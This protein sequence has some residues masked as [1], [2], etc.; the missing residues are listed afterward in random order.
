M[1]NDLSQSDANANDMRYSGGPSV[2]IFGDSDAAVSDIRDSVEANGARVSFQGQ[3]GE[4]L[5]AI[6]QQVSYDALL[7]DVRHSDQRTMAPVLGELRRIATHDRVPMLIS[8]SMDLLD[9]VVGIADA[10]RITLL[11]QPNVFE[12]TA[13]LGLALEGQRWH[14]NDVTAELDPMRLRLIADEV[15]RIAQALAKLT[16]SAPALSS[17]GHGQA[18]AV[19]D[20]M[21]GYR[22]EPVIEPLDANLPRAEDIRS[23]IRVR[24]LRDQHFDPLL[25]ADPA[26]DMLLDLMAARL[27]RAQVAVSSLCIAAAVPP[28]TALRWIK[29]MTDAGLFERCADPDDGRRI[30]IQLSDATAAALSRY[31]TAAKKL[32]GILI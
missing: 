30:F 11:C 31:F 14:L 3:P 6:G 19:N 2:L 9:D 26:W 5:S 17:P 18:S 8:T 25:F 22:V 10:E 23:I 4:A 1:N 24:R 29:S 15:S 27:E 20:M 28:T 12:R 32:G 13:A 16:P 21:I 7:L